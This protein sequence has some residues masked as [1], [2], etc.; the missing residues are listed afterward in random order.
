MPDIAQYQKELKRKG[1]VMGGRSRAGSF[2]S[3]GGKSKRSKSAESGDEKVVKKGKKRSPKPIIFLL[4]TG[5]EGWLEQPQKEDAEK[6]RFE[7]SHRPVGLLTVF[8]E[9]FDRTRNQM[10]GRSSTVHAPRGPQP[11]TN[12]KVLLCSCSSTC[13]RNNEMGGNLHPR[14]THRR[15]R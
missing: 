3:I 7:T 14:G 13:D 10:C 1:G 15:I 6:V 11:E 4:I 2:D 8:A 5:Y 9:S 12:G